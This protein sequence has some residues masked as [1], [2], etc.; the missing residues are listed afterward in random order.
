MLRRTPQPFVVFCL[1]SS[2]VLVTGSGCQKTDLTGYRKASEKRKA[3]A[4]APSAH[5]SA[6]AQSKPDA[7]ENESPSAEVTVSTAPAPQEVESF[8]VSALA[9]LNVVD[10]ADVRAL[11]NV[12]KPEIK[13]EQASVSTADPKPASDSAPPVHKVELLVKEKTFRPEKGALRVSFDDLDLLKVLNMEPVTDNAEELM[14]DWL[15]GLSGK[16]IRLRG[17]MY[18]TYETEGIERFVLARDNQICCFGRDPK[19]YDLVQVNMKTGKTTNYIPAVRSFDVVG[20]FQI[21]MMSED[22]KPYG[23]YFIDQAEVIER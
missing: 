14:P 10:G 2:L 7:V 13:I 15:H 23:L 6:V 9:P 4:D 11:M 21:K 8:P 5:D 3:P 18:P 22:G 12:A 16:K 20:T 17:F 19:V 1:A